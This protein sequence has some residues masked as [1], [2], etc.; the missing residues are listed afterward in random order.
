M[1]HAKA[2]PG[3]KDKIRPLTNKGWQ[4]LQ[5]HCKKNAW[6]FSK[7]QLVLCSS[8]KRTRETLEG[9]NN[10]LSG[11]VMISYIDE[12][13]GA[14]AEA[15]LKEISLIDEKFTTVMVIAH[16]PGVTDF[17]YNVCP[18]MYDHMPP[19]AVVEFK[20]EDLPWKDMNFSRLKFENFI[21]REPKDN[22]FNFLSVVM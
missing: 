5:H 12:L 21:G 18:K 6:L 20:M 19:S 10:C 16:N 4:E 11:R 7:V 14:D 8:S 2:E 9:L 22:A 13:Y 15:I 1:R 3:P 17:F